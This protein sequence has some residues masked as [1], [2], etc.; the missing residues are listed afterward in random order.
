MSLRARHALP[1]AAEK[2]F[3]S[4][5]HARRFAGH[6]LGL[7]HFWSPPSVGKSTITCVHGW[8]GAA[9]DAAL[10]ERTFSWLEVPSA[11]YMSCPADGDTV[12]K[13]HR[14]QLTPLST[15]LYWQAQKGTVAVDLLPQY[16]S[17]IGCRHTDCMPGGESYQPEIIEH[18]NKLANWQVYWQL[19]LHRNRTSTA[20]R[21]FFDWL[22]PDGHLRR[23]RLGAA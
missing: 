11:S 14:C 10:E 9:V 21:R 15:Y 8:V 1:W 17:A 5:R 12:V 6:M 20:G 22:T 3:D 4:Q 2:T 18:L 19:R 16:L 7:G 13:L 23:I